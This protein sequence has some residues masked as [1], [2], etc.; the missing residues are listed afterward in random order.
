MR[1]LLARA[2]LQGDDR[3]PAGHRQQG[4]LGAVDPPRTDPRARPAPRLGAVGTDRGDA[5]R[6]RP[7]RPRRRAALAEPRTGQLHRRVRPPR[8]TLGQAGRRRGQ[9][10]GG[11]TGGVAGKRCAQAIAATRQP[12]NSA[13]SAAPVS[14]RVARPKPG[15][16]TSTPSES[17]LSR[18]AGKRSASDARLPPSKR[19]PSSG[20]ARPAR[21][22]AKAPAKANRRWLQPRRASQ[23]PSPAAAP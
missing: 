2:D 8:R 15:S 13:A 22:P 3:H 9:G 12:T 16:P 4:R 10:A 23:T 1:A 18:E 21:A 6:K 17:R 19:P 7:P 11:G 20:V 14:I 5:A